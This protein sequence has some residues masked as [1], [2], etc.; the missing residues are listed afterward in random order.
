[1]IKQLFRKKAAQ[2]IGLDIGTRFVKA[3]MLEKDGDQY[4]VVGFA[5][6]PINGNAFAERE[7]KDFDAISNAL[8]RVKNTL[9][10]KQKDVV[11]AIAGGSVLTK[12]VY[13]D[14]DQT[15][16]ELEGQIE[17]EADSLIPYPL[18]EVYL[19]FEELGPSISHTGKVDVLL[20][21]AHK[22]VVDSRITLLREVQFEPRVMDIEGYA[23]GN[24]L[25]HFHAPNADEAQVCINIGASLLQVCVVKND[26]VIYSKEHAFGVDNLLQDLSLVHTM[27]REEIQQQLLQG[28]LP[29]NW[30]TD[31]Y[32][33]FLANLQQH[34]ARAMQMYISTTHAQRPET[35]LICGGGAN[36]E[37]IA[38]DLATELAVNVEVFNPFASMQVAQKLEE[39]GFKQVAPQLVLAA[40]LASR[41]FSEWH[42]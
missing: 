5:C 30:R 28:E 10:T 15:D 19:D 42:I 8:R 4:K 29:A 12:V 7:I 11:A 27:E 1:M 16:F 31:T 21:A 17:I 37:G 33:I 22:D 35:L 26:Q 20:S 25:D 41:S 14:P 38:S 32:P 34:I 23:L 18:D 13:M 9:K 36:I 2:F 6:E 24:A 40:G 39:Q 3:V